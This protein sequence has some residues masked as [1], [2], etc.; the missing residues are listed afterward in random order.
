[1]ISRLIFENYL[2]GTKRMAILMESA[3]G[4]GVRVVANASAVVRLSPES[5]SLIGE[6]NLNYYS[7]EGRLRILKVT[8]FSR[9]SPS[10]S[11]FPDQSIARRKGLLLLIRNALMQFTA[12]TP[13]NSQPSS[14]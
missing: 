14:Q 12:H 10:R 2:S 6:Q 4:C 13:A 8:T 1:V 9:G 11:L 3:E 5:A 7:R